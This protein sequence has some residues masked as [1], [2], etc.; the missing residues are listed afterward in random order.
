M[1]KLWKTE[2][3]GCMSREKERRE[4]EERREKRRREWKNS[5]RERDRPKEYD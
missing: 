3:K 2:E 5:D 1:I 4:R